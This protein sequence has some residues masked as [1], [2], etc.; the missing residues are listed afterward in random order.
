MGIKETEG[1][2][3][4]VSIDYYDVRAKFLGMVRDGKAWSDIGPYH[5]SHNQP[6]DSRLQGYA[7]EPDDDGEGQDYYWDHRRRGKKGR[8]CEA[9]GSKGKIGDGIECAYCLGRGTTAWE[10]ARPNDTVAWIENGFRAP[11]FSHSAEYIPK[12]DKRRA[13][14]NEE[15]GEVDLGRLYGGYDDFFMDVMNRPS[16][17]GMRIQIEYSFSWTTKPNIIAE[18][19]AWCA[20]FIRSLEMSGY[21]L[22]V[23]MWIHLDDLYHGD[24][25]QRT[26]VLIRVKREN[27]VSNFTEWS[28][29]FSPSGYRHLGF[30]AKCIAGDKIKKQ[31]TG[32][33]GTCIT[34]DWDVKYDN[35]RST[36]L[37]TC[38]QMGGSN[39]GAKKK[40]M[41]AAIREGLLPGVIEDE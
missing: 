11:E 30:L 35:E 41:K 9:C 5:S 3:R 8:P 6:M 10:G 15:Q 38:N 37:I 25:N 7:R 29:L 1:K 17:P 14:W 19:G 31:A 18:Y 28:A 32:S 2:H 36:T 34:G 21:D 24:Y 4:H 26:S 22:V 39:D 40:L 33:L 27:E 20:G 12:H 16:R 13:F 23:D